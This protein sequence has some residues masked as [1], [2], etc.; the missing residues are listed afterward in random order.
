MKRLLAVFVMMFL[1]MSTVTTAAS[2]TT[3]TT[4]SFYLGI[5]ESVSQELDSLTSVSR[6]RQVEMF[7]CLLGVITPNYDSLIVTAAYDPGVIWTEP[8]GMLPKPCPDRI[9]VGDW[10]THSPLRMARVGKHRAPDGRP[11]GKLIIDGFV[12]EKSVCKM[13]EEDEESTR[14]VGRGR[15]YLSVIQVSKRTKCAWALIVGSGE[16][17]QLDWK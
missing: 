3:D 11:L 8:D 15:V 6:K 10:H 13:S 12:P 14:A 5:Y 7:R 16:L 2:Q 1:T 4:D 9:T 17:V